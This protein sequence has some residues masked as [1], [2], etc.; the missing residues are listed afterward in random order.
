MQI[1]RELIRKTKRNKF[2]G[3][4]FKKCWKPWNFMLFFLALNKESGQFSS[5][6][7]K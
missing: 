2:F 5:G 4:G 7:P 1:K 3:E 6:L